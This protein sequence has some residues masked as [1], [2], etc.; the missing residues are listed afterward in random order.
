[1]NGVELAIT[2]AT[3]VAVI[4]LSWAVAVLAEIGNTI[5]WGLR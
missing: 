4:A 1:M 2:A 3:A 5:V